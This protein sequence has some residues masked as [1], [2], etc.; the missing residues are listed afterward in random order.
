MSV[1]KVHK[2]RHT[3][4]KKLRTGTLMDVP[5]AVRRAEAAIAAISDKL[6]A[7]VDAD[8]DLAEAALADYLRN[9][10]PDAMQ[11]IYD[12]GDRLA[13]ICAACG[14]RPLA[15]AA[16]G[17]CELLDLMATSGRSDA[18]AVAVH[19]SALRLL[20]Q[21]DE[22][23]ANVLAGLARVRQRFVDPEQA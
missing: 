7:A 5:L 15:D 13:G 11:R 14:L 17:A 12:C 3:L 16:L 23:S 6:L 8:L 4:A 19:V 2:P 9:P 20:R 22:G 18:R 1:V 10:T 21:G